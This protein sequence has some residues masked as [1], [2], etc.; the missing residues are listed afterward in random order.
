MDLG[1]SAEGPE[2]YREAAIAAMK[3]ISSRCTADL[4]RNC[5]ELNPFNAFQIRID[6][7]TELMGKEIS[8]EQFVGSGYDFNKN[9]LNLFTYDGRFK[10][11]NHNNHGI[12]FALLCPPH[13][14]RVTPPSL[15]PTFSKAYGLDETRFLE[16]II[17]DFFQEFLFCKSAEE[18]SHLEIYEWS[19]NWSNYF[20]AGKEWWGTFYWTIFNKNNR[21]ITVIGGSTTD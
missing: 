8:F 3:I 9:E 2:A 4:L 20:D 6:P 11:S 12:A 13:G 14:L 10:T 15:A 19:D 16:G 17:A 1:D 21:T 7:G 18:H 5:P